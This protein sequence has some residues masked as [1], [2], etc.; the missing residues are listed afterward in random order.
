MPNSL[1]IG[2]RT[3]DG[4]IPV[5]FEADGVAT[6]GTLDPAPLDSLGTLDAVYQALNDPI[7]RKRAEMLGK[8]LFEALIS[9]GSPLRSAWE[10]AWAHDPTGGLEL[11]IEEPDLRA[12]PW[13]LLWDAQDNRPALLGGVVRRVP[14]ASLSP[15]RSQ[16]PFRIL[17]IVGADESL[18]GADPIGAAQEVEAIRRELIDFG[19]SIDVQVLAQPTQD[20]VRTTLRTYQPHVVHFIGHGM[21]DLATRRHAL[22]IEAPAADGGTWWWDTVSLKTDFHNAKCTPRLVFLNACR[23]GSSRQSNISL[24]EVLTERLLIGVVMAM[25]A[26]VRGDRAARFSQRFYRH[27]LVG[28]PAA[29]ELPSIVE[30]VQQGREALGAD[31]DID[32]GLP[33]LT[34]SA[35]VP[36]DCRLR[37]PPSLSTDGGFLVC[38]QFM[39]AR[40]YADEERTR[41][42]MIEWMYPVDQGQTPNILILQGLPASGKSRL[43]HWCMESW[44][45][46]CQTAIRYL[47]VE[48]HAGENC[49]KWLIRLRSGQPAVR[50][51]DAFLQAALPLEPF[52]PFYDQ[53]ARAAGLMEGPRKVDDPQQRIALIDSHREEVRDDVAIAS[54]CSRFL[55]GLDGLPPTILVFDQLTTA[56]IRPELFKP[57]KDAFLAPLGKR[58]TPHIRAVLAVTTDDYRDFKLATLDDQTA[59]VVTMRTDAYS[60][61]EL[62][63]LAVEALRYKDESDLRTLARIYVGKA[64][65]HVGLAR[66]RFCQDLLELG[67][68]VNLER[69]R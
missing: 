18:P 8:R 37:T 45:A 20:V 24:Q 7:N 60:V 14:R 52:Q 27:A 67:P 63:N 66:L 33:A 17:I 48:K 30:A 56:A 36:I 11:T 9:D 3:G 32:W 1:T 46:T 4:R 59:R 43:L 55:E 35:G 23:S 10:H 22:V 49:L 6:A 47:A 21:L 34:F 28:T 58:P 15:S 5:T 62:E 44:A 13:E 38:R 16:W 26:D 61:K 40:V 50:E 53:V 2:K 69:M 51:E 64:Q 19:R 29:A 12:Y 68:Y 39:D 41:R 42:A 31:T 54:F 25:Q 65:R 57:F